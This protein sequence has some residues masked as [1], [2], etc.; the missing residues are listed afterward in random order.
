MNAIGQNATEKRK[1]VSV[2]NAGK[3]LIVEGV[4]AVFTKYYAEALLIYENIQQ[5]RAKLP[6]SQWATI[7]EGFYEIEHTIWVESKCKRARYARKHKKFIKWSYL[8]YLT[9]QSDNELI[10]KSTF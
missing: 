9:E 3:C 7:K 10:P 6:E 2:Y 4:F 5:Q 1:T 8:W